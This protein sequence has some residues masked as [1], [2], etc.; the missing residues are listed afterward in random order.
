MNSLLYKSK[1]K[2]HLWQRH[3]QAA[4]RFN[5]VNARSITSGSQVLEKYK[6]NTL[7][8]LFGVTLGCNLN[9]RHRK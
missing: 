4:H 2:R 8:F 1:F 3:L 5:T 9:N 7:K 6:Y